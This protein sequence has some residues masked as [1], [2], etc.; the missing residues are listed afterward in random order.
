VMTAA[1]VVASAND[2]QAGHALS[3]IQLIFG[4]PDGN[5][6]TVAGA[7]VIHFDASADWAVL[8]LPDGAPAIAGRPFRL[9]EPSIM[10]GLQWNTFGYSSIAPDHG[11]AYG[12]VV[13]TDSSLFQL[14]VDPTQGSPR[15]LSGS[16]CLVDGEVIGVVVESPQ[17]QLTDTLYARSVANL[18]KAC[19]D[20]RVLPK[21][22]PYVRYVA[23]QLTPFEEH[24]WRTA[25]LLGL[26]TNAEEAEKI[27]LKSRL[28]LRVALEMMTGTEATLR[29]IRNLRRAFEDLKDKDEDKP[30]TVAR[31]LL[32]LAS[33]VWIDSGTIV[34]LRRALDAE[35]VVILNTDKADVVGSYLHRLNWMEEVSD[36]ERYSLAFCVDPAAP[37]S[38]AVKVA[39]D[40]AV[41]HVLGRRHPSA[42]VALAKHD[43]D[44][45]PL[46]AWF[47][48]LPEVSTIKAL[49]DLRGGYERVRLLFVVG[50]QSPVLL[51]AEYSD[52]VIL[53]PAPLL[54]DIERAVTAFNEA[55]ETV[56]PWFESKGSAA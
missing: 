44:G 36:P 47:R 2:S 54:T 53:T 48:G 34:Q 46:V 7:R 43:H 12:G 56:T 35:Q 5:G 23:K 42:Q 17:I 30:L 32:E 27:I 9:R 41:L 29:S 31:E 38:N 49:R 3:D 40:E 55:L 15:G 24:L 50:E 1:H 20:A 45:E 51:E 11:Q 10:D 6:V 33:R 8:Q 28:P 18:G 25:A 21:S 39:F 52:G 37:T 16:P 4:N 22:A 13:L 26:A 19:A 14:R